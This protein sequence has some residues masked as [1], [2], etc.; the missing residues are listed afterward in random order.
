MKIK[1]L[2]NQEN[3]IIHNNIYGLKKEEAKEEGR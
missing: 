3:F 1:H 2:A